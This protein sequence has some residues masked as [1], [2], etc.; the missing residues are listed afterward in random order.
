MMMAHLDQQQQQQQQQQCSFSPSGALSYMND[1]IVYI[2]QIHIGNK[3]KLLARKIVDSRLIYSIDNLKDVLQMLYQHKFPIEM[4]YT[5]F[6][7]IDR[8]MDYLFLATQ[9]DWPVDRDLEKEFGVLGLFKTNFAHH[10]AQI[11]HFITTTKKDAVAD[12]TSSSSSATEDEYK[13]FLHLLTVSLDSLNKMPQ[14]NNVADIARFIQFISYVCNDLNDL[15][16]DL[17]I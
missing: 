2:Q 16:E 7:S 6:L 10:L 17:L 14:M 3:D 9:S 4:R 12:A 8:M 11:I 1:E 5:L 15:K 13:S